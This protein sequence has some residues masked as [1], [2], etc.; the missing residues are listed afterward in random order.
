MQSYHKICPCGA[1]FDTEYES[2]VY[3]T[4]KCQT[5]IK[6]QRRKGRDQREREPE[7]EKGVKFFNLNNPTVAQL[8]EL[9]KGMA[10]GLYPEGAIVT[11]VVPMWSV[12]ETV[13]FAEHTPGIWSMQKAEIDV[14]EL[15]KK[16]QTGVMSP[17]KKD[18]HLEEYGG[19]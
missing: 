16:E 3:C 19:Q 9:S 5:R 13:W 6:A 14:M 7:V 10:L 15:Y 11:G 18:A 8:D 2:R 4:L 1:P 12:P 17:I